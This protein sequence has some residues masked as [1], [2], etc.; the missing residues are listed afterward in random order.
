[1]DS[2]CYV[3]D[4]MCTYKYMHARTVNEKR[5]AAFEGD[6]GRIYGEFGGR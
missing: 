5:D 3:Q 2:T 1:M 6:Q 4:Y